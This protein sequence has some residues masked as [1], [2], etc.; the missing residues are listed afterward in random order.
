LVIAAVLD[1]NVLLSGLVGARHP[2]SPPGQ[3]VSAWR[4][5]AF[6]LVLSEHIVTEMVRAL[7]K[8]YFLRRVTHVR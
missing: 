3:I 4:D 1:A 8:P 2:H 6:E 7:Q 5:R